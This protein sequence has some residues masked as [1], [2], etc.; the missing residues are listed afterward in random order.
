MQW[1]LCL[2]SARLG[3][4]L[5]WAAEQANQ[6]VQDPA[7]GSFNLLSYLYRAL[8]MSGDA[9]FVEPLGAIAQLYRHGSNFRTWRL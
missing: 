4:H 9:V 8:C 2:A 5:A 7:H 1:Y 3:C 6:I